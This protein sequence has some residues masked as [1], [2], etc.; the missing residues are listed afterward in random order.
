MSLKIC[1]VT[2][3]IGRTGGNRVL[4]SGNRL[5]KLEYGVILY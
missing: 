5:A 1:F 4:F 3:E 2:W